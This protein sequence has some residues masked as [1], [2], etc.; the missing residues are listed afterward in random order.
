MNKSILRSVLLGLKYLLNNKHRI[1][2]YSYFMSHIIFQFLYSFSSSSNLVILAKV[3]D[4]S[5]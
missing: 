2:K 1:V 5:Q 3:L 4:T